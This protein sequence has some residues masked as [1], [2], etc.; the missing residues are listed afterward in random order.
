MDFQPALQHVLQA[1]SIS[2]VTHQLPDGDAIGSGLALAQALTSLGKSTHLILEKAV[3]SSFSYLPFNL[4]VIDDQITP[5]E[6][7]VCLDMPDY[8]RSNLITRKQA[9]TYS[10]L[11]IDHHPLGDLAQLSSVF[12]H[13]T[14][15]CST[16]ELV[17]HF[18]VALGARITPSIATCLLTGIYTD[19]GGFQHANTTGTTLA[20]SSELMQ[21]GA[22]LH[23][24]TTH[25]TKNKSLASLKLLGLALERLRVSS[26]GCS[27]SY[28]TH[29]DFEK[30]QAKPEDLLGIIGEL[31]SMSDTTCSILLSEA[32]DGIIRGSIRTGDGSSFSSS[33]L[34]Q[35]LGG[36]G[37]PKAAGFSFSGQI[38]S[39]RLGVDIV[40]NA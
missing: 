2:I 35:L 34:A 5:C 3:P 22:A 9:E 20:L 19:T 4:A 10:I 16:A 11:T 17:Y 6:L 13:S 12:L 29:A 8:R 38:H 31:A 15:A 33:K 25:L 39:N 28:L 7:L 14:T 36:G 21:R 24:I 32:E 40:T 26:F 1:Q 37:H 27:V 18:I 30:T 23:T